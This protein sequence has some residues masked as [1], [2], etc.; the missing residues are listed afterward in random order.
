MGN[1]NCPII[2][3]FGIGSYMTYMLACLSLF[4]YSN[5]TALELQTLLFL[6]FPKSA[7]PN[8]G[9]GSSKDAAYT[10]TFMVQV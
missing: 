1:E 7:L 10:R 8:S 5:T 9:C 4:V 2:G 3:L 6:F